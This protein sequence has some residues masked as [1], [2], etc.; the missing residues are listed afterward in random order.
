MSSKA[1]GRMKILCISNGHGEDG[2]AVRVLKA[3]HRLPDAP[4]TVAMPIVGEGEAFQKAG[5][6]ITGPTQTLPS[7]GF[8]Y[9]D[10][11]QLAQDVR[12]GL[13]QLTLGQLRAAKAWAQEGGVIFAVG[14]VVPLAIAA[15]SGAPYA[16]LGTAKS[17]YWLRNEAGPLPNRPWF[18]GWS[19]SVYLPWERWLMS[20]QRCQRVFVRDL[21]TAE[22]LQQFGVP[23]VYA[24][25]PMMDALIPD[26]TKRV[27]LTQNLPVSTPVL[28]LV[29]LPGSR[30]PEA[31]R[32]WVQILQAVDS[33]AVSY[34]RKSLQFFAA[35]APALALDPLHRAL[36]E[37]GWNSQ[38]AIYPTYYKENACLRIAQ[39]AF[40]ECLDLAEGAIA[41]AG[42]ATEQIVGLG[43]PAFIFP[44]Q[45][46]QF[47]RTFAQVQ[48]RLL[49]TS[50]L[51]TETPDAVGQSV[52]AL[53]ED[54][55]RLQAIRLN[56][57][58]RM[59]AAGACDAIAS[60]LKGSFEVFSS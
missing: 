8:I 48:A 5:I 23:A 57:Q 55:A 52:K 6:A 9:M 50:V 25:N 58:H 39:D 4:E 26:S 3:L 54:P 32:N 35:I 46:P 49:G 33:V 19:G 47:T 17:E 7:G 28:T 12:S 22:K 24:G 45:G 30:S 40:A 51:L 59:G 53:F 34:P 13:V 27:K 18:E 43:K 2:I 10:S 41:T 20:R 1:E 29:L 56:G 36:T 31:E 42:T 21:I 37:A 60:Q 14:D 11:R 44:G 15:L 38:S 16:F